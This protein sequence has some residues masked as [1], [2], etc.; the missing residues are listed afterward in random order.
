MNCQ[1]NSPSLWVSG[2]RALNAGRHPPW[3][4]SF[5][6]VS[7]R[8]STAL[9]SAHFHRPRP[10]HSFLW[11]CSFIWHVLNSSRVQ[12][13]TVDYVMCGDPRRKG[14]PPPGRAPAWARDQ[15]LHS[16]LQHITEMMRSS[17]SDG[18]SCPI[19]VTAVT[20][21]HAATEIVSFNYWLKFWFP[22]LSTLPLYW[23]SRPPLSIRRVKLLCSL[24]ILD[25]A[26][27]SFI[28]EIRF[29]SDEVCIYM[30]W[31][32]VSLHSQNIGQLTCVSVYVFFYSD[33]WLNVSI[34][35]LNCLVLLR[36]Q[37]TSQSR[38]T[39]QFC[40][41]RFTTNFSISF[42]HNFSIWDSSFWLGWLHKAMSFW[43]GPS[44]EY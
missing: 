4:Y 1:R 8:N 13:I 10:A 21:S 11:L 33:T 37:L 18:A 12:H 24:S 19:T 25:Q 41:L 26:V 36:C 23:A 14:P 27:T 44:T 40:S 16:Y 17:C 2:W 31:T 28:W 43:S 5:T 7:L 32:E 29:P 30:L 34:N 3:L 9:Q 22:Y 35:S 38:E 39:D 42:N 20:K 6:P 15:R